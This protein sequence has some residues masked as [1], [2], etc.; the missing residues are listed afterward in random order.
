MGTLVSV[1][2]QETTMRALGRR[3]RSL[4]RG[5]WIHRRSVR[6]RV[7]C[8]WRVIC[9]ARRS[10]SEQ[11]IIITHFISTFVA[12]ARSFINFTSF[13]FALF[14]SLIFS[15]REQGLWGCHGWNITAGITRRAGCSP[16]CPVSR[17]LQ[18]NRYWNEGAKQQEGQRRT[19]SYDFQDVV[20]AAH[21]SSI[22]T[23]M[24][25]VD[26]PL[27]ATLWAETVKVNKVKVCL[28]IMTGKTCRGS[29]PNFIK[30]QQWKRTRSNGI[31]N[32]FSFKR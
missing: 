10:V 15:S 2:R 11:K 30:T 6:C 7:S 32:H 26:I 5:W 18:P 22:S 12:R 21:T 16:W 20:S 4:R 29:S 27:R 9:T 24:L 28:F 3:W 13:T 17:S 1:C 25:I 31:S 19:A 8:P 23:G 14:V